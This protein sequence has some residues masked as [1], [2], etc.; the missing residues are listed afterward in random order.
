M[1]F[2]PPGLHHLG[3]SNATHPNDLF[4]THSAEHLL[5][6]LTTVPHTQVTSAIKT[7]TYSYDSDYRLLTQKPSLTPPGGLTAQYSYDA[8]GN[9]I[10][11]EVTNTP[12]TTT[13]SLNAMA[14]NLNQ[15]ATVNGTTWQYDA[16]GN[17]I[18]DGSFQYAWDAAHRLI[19]VVNLSTGHITSFKYDGLGRRLTIDEQDSGGVATET[20]YLWC[21]RMICGARN[22][23]NIVSA[24]YYSQGELHGSQALYYAR[25]QIGTVTGVM[26]ASGEL[27]GADQYSPYGVAKVVTDTQSDFQYAGMLHNAA[28]GLYL[29][30]F[31]EYNPAVGRWLSRDPIGEE[32]GENIYVYV[33]GNPL[34]GVDPLGL[35][36]AIIVGDA[37]GWNFAGHVAIA[38]TGQGVYRYGTGTAFGSSATAYMASQATYRSSTVYVLDTTPAQEAAMVAYLNDNYSPQSGRHY[39]I[40]NHSCATAVNGALGSQG[41]GDDAILGVAQAGGIMLPQ[42]PSTAGFIGSTYPGA[43]I[44]SIPQGA[45][46]PRS[47]LSFNPA[48]P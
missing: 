3:V 28:T 14:N 43:S 16:D 37:S 47:L 4:V 17:L 34:T 39:S 5:L 38:F 36:T 15:L 48:G 30:Q 31:R 45:A 23:Q 2:L 10:Q 20:R 18:N 22:G 8:V 44:I 29:T 19:S 9:L 46:I 42:L 25:D 1:T 41:I 21:G 27:L 12:S 40:F 32:G 11:S 35:A 26:N 33:G 13:D 7:A 24:D 6:T